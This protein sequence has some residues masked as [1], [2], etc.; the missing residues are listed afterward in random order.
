MCW[1]LSVLF[2]A[3][4]PVVASLGGG[5]WL[6]ASSR[7]LSPAPV[8]YRTS[9]PISSLFPPKTWGAVAVIACLCLLLCLLPPLEASQSLLESLQWNHLG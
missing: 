5:G 9:N 6:L 4:I 3:L 8:L 7:L 2:S 1:K